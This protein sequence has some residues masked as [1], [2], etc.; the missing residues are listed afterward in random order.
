V[1]VLGQNG[2]RVAD[3]FVT[4]QVRGYRGVEALCR[5]ELGE[6]REARCEGAEQLAERGR[7]YMELRETDALAG[8]AQ[9]FNVHVVPR[10][11]GCHK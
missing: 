5:D 10:T 1:I 7:R 9:K 6:S 3:E 11:R 2:V 4:I 8:N